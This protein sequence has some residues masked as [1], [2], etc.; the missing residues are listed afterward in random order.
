MLV[1]LDSEQ[2][3]E[4]DVH[5]A[6]RNGDRGRAHDKYQE[7]PHRDAAG[8]R[9]LPRDVDHSRRQQ[10]PSPIEDQHVIQ[11]VPEVHVTRNAIL[12]EKEMRR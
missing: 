8:Q 12:G 1:S 11:Q 6:M 3:D 4:N 9:V 2:Q 10:R 7:S 5:N